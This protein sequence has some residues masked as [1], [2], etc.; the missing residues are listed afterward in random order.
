MFVLLSPTI[1]KIKPLTTIIFIQ[2]INIK[3]YFI[4]VK[5]KYFNFFNGMLLDEFNVLFKFNKLYK[6]NK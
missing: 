2:V 3:I 1:Y 5:K 6:L 4:F